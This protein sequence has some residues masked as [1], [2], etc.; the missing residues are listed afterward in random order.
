MLADNPEWVKVSTYVSRRFVELESSQPIPTLQSRLGY[1]LMAGSRNFDLIKHLETMRRRGTPI[2]GLTVLFVNN[3]NT[4]LPRLIKQASPETLVLGRI[5]TVDEP[6]GAGLGD[7]N[8]DSWARG[9]LWVKSLSSQMAN[10]YVDYWQ[11]ANEWG[12]SMPEFP[13][14]AELERVQR[15]AEA[16]NNFYIAASEQARAIGKTITV[17]DFSV[18]HLEDYSLP[19]FAPLFKYAQ[20]NGN[21]INY[22]AYN[23]DSNTGI[24]KPILGNNAE[25]YYAG[26]FIRWTHRY[27][28]LRV[29]LG[30]AGAGDA[31]YSRNPALE[32][33][34]MRELDRLC[35]GEVGL[36][37]NTLFATNVLFFAWWSLFPQNDWLFSDFAAAIPEIERAW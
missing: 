29:I 30:E 15:K 3:T 34:R 31:R 27:P 5:Y 26:R 11:I 23:G 6:H 28:K 8:P 10:P 9:D 16:F 24:D 1:H 32:M 18:G 17:G 33:Q 25:F 13:S 35:R 36:N 21:P 12:T 37:N 19:F 22:H 2:A 4:D 20:E 7:P 14:G